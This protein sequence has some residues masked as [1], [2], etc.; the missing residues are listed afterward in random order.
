MESFYAPNNN[1]SSQKLFTGRTA[2]F[3]KL[4]KLIKNGSSIALYGE[5]RIG[6]T[7]FLRMLQKMLNDNLI[8]IDNEALPFSKIKDKLIDG[9]LKTSVD[10]FQQE[11]QDFKVLYVSLLSPDSEEE[12]II[13]L[14]NALEKQLNIEHEFPE[15]KIKK[16][17]DF[18]S[19]LYNDTEP[20]IKKH[21]I[22]I[23]D[24]IEELKKFKGNI[25]DQLKK[26]N[27]ENGLVH[28]I[29]AGSFAW[30]ENLALDHNKWNYLSDFYLKGINTE[31][32]YEFLIKPIRQFWESKNQGF[33][34][35]ILTE[36][37]S[38]TGGRPLLIQEICS[39]LTKLPPEE[40]TNELPTMQSNYQRLLSSKIQKNLFEDKNIN[41]FDK[42][43]LRLLSH[44]SDKT[45]DELAKIV[46]EPKLKIQERLNRFIDFGT[47]KKENDKYALNGVLLEGVGKKFNFEIN[48]KEK[49]ESQ[50]EKEESQ[51]RI[52][53][54]KNKAE[55]KRVKFIQNILATLFLI[56]AIAIFFY[57]DNQSKPIHS[58]T[59]FETTYLSLVTPKSVEGQIN[60]EE[61]IFYLTSHAQDTIKALKLQFLSNKHILFKDNNGKYSFEY[62]N[63]L[64]NEERRGSI[65]FQTLDNLPDIIK[66]NVSVNNE[67]QEFKLIKGLPINRWSRWGNKIISI[68]LGLLGLFTF[69]TKLS[70]VPKLIETISKL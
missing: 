45:I 41:K 32:A 34:E 37:T 64:L 52:A 68:I 67:I 27:E 30:Q 47:V 18:I 54:T 43:L 1:N 42:N 69:S 28:F 13:K 16:I 22:I 3:S 63:L 12:L 10:S 8:S 48:Q 29:Y 20:I 33:K 59:K 49:K 14:I 65:S 25:I 53:S 44:H 38:F 50:K 35:E 2:D 36:I 39:Y 40:I 6:K 9:K 51:N 23:F 5:R 31:D 19:Y 11:Y 55:Q 15:E 70:Y 57:K 66:Y 17:D 58:K 60:D 7:L 26:I 46:Y 4:L 21:L 62:Q 24:E 61:I 56:A